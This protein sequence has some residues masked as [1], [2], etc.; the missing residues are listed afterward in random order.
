MLSRTGLPIVNYTHKTRYVQI[1]FQV[2]DLERNLQ[3][4]SPQQTEIRNKLDSLYK[5]LN[6]L[7]H[8]IYARK[9]CEQAFHQYFK[10]V[11]FQVDYGQPCL[12]TKSRLSKLV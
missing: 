2:S 7:K 1:S 11:R 6:E 4:L 8:E 5:E 9:Y 3:T 10:T 12:G